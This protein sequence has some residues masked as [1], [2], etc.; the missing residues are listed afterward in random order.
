VTPDLMQRDRVNFSAEQV[1]RDC[2]VVSDFLQRLTHCG[3]FTAFMRRHPDAPLAEV[4]VIA[5]LPEGM[6][7]SLFYG[8][9]ELHRIALF[10]GLAAQ[11]VPSETLRRVAAAALRRG[12][13]PSS[14]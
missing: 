13:P 11:L 4:H 1:K 6:S 10:V 14:Q 3:A 5:T 8:V 12:G 2:V 7:P 9:D